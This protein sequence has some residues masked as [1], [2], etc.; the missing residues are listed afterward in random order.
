M[1]LGVKVTVEG[2]SVLQDYIERYPDVARKA[3]RLAINDTLRKGRVKIKKRIMEKV[4]LKSR[5]LDSDRLYVDLANDSTLSGK[6]VGRY[7]S[8]SLARFEAR[9]LYESGTKRQAGVS[10]RVK[11]VQ[12]KIPKAFLMNLKNENKGVAIRLKPGEKPKRRFEAKPLYSSRGPNAGKGKDIYLL[13]GPSIHQVM[14]SDKQGPSILE[15]VRPELTQYLNTEFKRQF[16]R[17]SNG[18]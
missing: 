15:E 16:A 13:Y 6:I 10:V 12:R 17:L 5:Y 8:T 4:N 1:S 9:Q 11:N 3:A 2:D 7:R 14:T 18:R